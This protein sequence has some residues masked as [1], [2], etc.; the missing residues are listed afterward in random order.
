MFP[1]SE[2]QPSGEVDALTD[3]PDPDVLLERLQAEE[4]RARRAR[5]K[6]W[7]G[8]APGVGKTFAMLENARALQEAGV[9]VAVGWVDTHGRY[10]TAALLLGLDIVPRR[11]I[12]HRG[13]ELADLGL[14]GVVDL[15]AALLELGAVRLEGG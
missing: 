9:D 4:M 11:R 1:R 15:V 6:V 3:R 5:L 8:F 14:D 7:L 12:T 13:V 10:D 2:A